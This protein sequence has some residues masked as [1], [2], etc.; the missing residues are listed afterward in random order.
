MIILIKKKT[1]YIAL[2][3]VLITKLHNNNAIC[4]CRP[5]LRS[6]CRSTSIEKETDS[7]GG[8][9]LVVGKVEESLAPT[10]SSTSLR[11]EAAGGGD[12]ASSGLE[13][14]KNRIVDIYR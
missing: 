13:S 3:T 5:E 9:W 4:K 6:F 14:L 11:L 1:I 2:I 12:T 7:I 8:M 10:A